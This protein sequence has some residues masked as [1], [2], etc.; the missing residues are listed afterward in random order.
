MLDTAIALWVCA[1][2]HHHIMLYVVSGD[3]AE[4]N[5]SRKCEMRQPTRYRLDVILQFGR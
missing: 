5:V 1:I 4:I 3:V 2:K